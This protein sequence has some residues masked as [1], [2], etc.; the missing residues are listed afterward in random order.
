MAS[1]SSPSWSSNRTAAKSLLVAATATTAALLGG[2]ALVDH[3]FFAGALRRKL[4]RAV[5]G[6]AAA[7]AAAAAPRYLFKFASLCSIEQRCEGKQLAADALGGEGVLR[8]IEE[9]PCLVTVLVL[10]LPPPPL[11]QQQQQQPVD[12]SKL[13]VVGTG[14]LK[15]GVQDVELESLVGELERYIARRRDSGEARD[16]ERIE[17]EAISAEARRL[18]RSSSSLGGEAFAPVLVGEAMRPFKRESATNS[19]DSLHSGAEAVQKKQQRRYQRRLIAAEINFLAVDP[20]HRGNGLGVALTN[21]LGAIAVHRLSVIEVQGTAASESL[22][23]GFYTKK[24][25]PPV[26]DPF[27]KQSQ[28]FFS[29]DCTHKEV[30]EEVLARCSPER[31]PPLFKLHPALHQMIHE[32][33]LL[34][35][36]DFGPI[37]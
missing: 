26:L 34:C 2:A 33:G 19:N 30:H 24:C 21:V 4:L 5:G 12:E 17:M 15:P 31:F 29:I 14:I 16:D 22:A 35:R 27:M 13:K 20:A 23:A 7:A 3:F 37:A 18:A 11:Q 9:A 32:K 25:A 8:A 36:P 1:S 6:G 10:L 28:Q